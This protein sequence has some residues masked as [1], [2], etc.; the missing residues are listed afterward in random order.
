MTTNKVETER[1]QALASKKSAEDRL[2]WKEKELMELQA[3]YDE[4]MNQLNS[5]DSN[6]GMTASWFLL[7]HFKKGKDEFGSGRV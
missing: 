4:L 3:K 7:L 5:P 2:S 6:L 1:D